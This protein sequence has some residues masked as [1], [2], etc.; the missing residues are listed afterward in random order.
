MRN[1]RPTGLLHAIPVL[2]L[3]CSATAETADAEST[4][5]PT[6]DP[7]DAFG[8][9]NAPGQDCP[10][11]FDPDAVY[12]AIGR[13]GTIDS[14]MMLVDLEDRSRECAFAFTLRNA[15]ETVDLTLGVRAPDGQLLRTQP[16]DDNHGQLQILMAAEPDALERGVSWS[17]DDLWWPRAFDGGNDETLVFDFFGHDCGSL[18]YRGP[19]LMTYGPT[20]ELGY[21][22]DD[23]SELRG[24]DNRVLASVTRA[25]PVPLLFLSDGRVV[26]VDDGGFD[27]RELSLVPVGADIEESEIVHLQG[28]AGLTVSA[29]A[30]QDVAGTL[31]V[32]GAV[33]DDGMNTTDAFARLHVE[34]DQLVLDHAFVDPELDSSLDQVVIDRAG[35]VTVLGRRSDQGDGIRVLVVRLDAAG[36]EVLYDAPDLEPRELEEMPATSGAMRIDRLI[37]PL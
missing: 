12:A 28:P 6:G 27:T 14:I 33:H 30:V 24:F 29:H 8:D 26:M 22:C 35:R 4:G 17:F 3:A 23:K 7:T 19:R 15:M 32:V 11:T 1:H 21:F 20:G 34:G 18:V 37:A 31:V 25:G 36:N 9:P 2:L 5:D 13:A 16:E 10:E